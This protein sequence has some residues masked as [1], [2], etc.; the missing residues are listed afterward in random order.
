MKMGFY[1]SLY[2][3]FNPLWLKDRNAVRHRAHAP[4]VQGRRHALSRPAI[5][6]SDGEWDMTSARMEERGIAGVAV[7]RVALQGRGRGQ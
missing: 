3:W 5:I 7:Q 2:E 6:F 1:Y 4:P